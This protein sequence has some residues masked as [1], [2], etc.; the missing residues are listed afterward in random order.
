M[1]FSRWIFIIAGIYGIIILVPMFFSEYQIGVSFPPA[2]TH[3]EYFYGFLSITLIW[4]FL[5]LFIAFNLL[6][7]KPI[8]LFC[9]LEKLGYGIAIIFLLRQ[10]RIAPMML[11]AGVLDLLFAVLF[12]LSFIKT[13]EEKKSAEKDMEAPITT[14]EVDHR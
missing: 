6:R 7:Y 5:F 1:K 11:S 9:V 2:I 12:L 3:P 10:G 13:K 8:M 4:Q 14:K